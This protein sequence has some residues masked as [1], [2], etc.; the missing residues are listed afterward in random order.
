MF[1]KI[2]LVFL[3]LS[4][5]SHAQ[6][7]IKGVLNVDGD[8]PYMILYKLKGITTQY[9]AYDTIVN[10]KFS[11]AVPP[12][13]TNGIYRMVYDVPNKLFVDIIYAKENIA[14]TFDPRNPNQT[15]QFTASSNNKI[16]YEYLN[17]IEKIQKE[18]DA[19][20]ITY[21]KNA[22]EGSAQLYVQKYAELTAMQSKYEELATD[23][24]AFH[25]IKASARFNNK[26]LI[27][28]PEEY[29]K[30]TQDH[31]FD[32]IDFNSKELAESTFIFDKINDYIFF[33]NSSDDP[34]QLQVLR[35]A[36]I[37]TVLTKI[38]S[39]Y[40]LAKD[41]N[42]SLLASFA[43]QED[44]NMVNF[45]LNQYLQMPREYQDSNYIS[46]IKG[47]L[48]TAVGMKVPNITWQENEQSMDLYSLADADRYIVV[49]WSSTC[50]H[51]LKEMPLLYDYLK[52]NT[53]TKVIAVGLEDTTSKAGWKTLIGG[54]KKFTHVYGEDKWKNNYAREYGVNATPSFYVLDANKK[55]LSKPDDVEAL[56]HYFS[57]K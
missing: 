49:F 50:S 35:R 34:T 11:I 3:F 30:V 29:F 27:K 4:T 20:Q 52:D 23:K 22:S 25:F 6:Y 54:F 45:V 40:T 43:Q 36:A 21:F 18:L 1:K 26:S 41:I 7:S 14:F 57:T 5:L 53:T 56:K 38:G 32:Y 31:F 9:V 24:L 10:R 19:L 16:Y 39:N 55:V 28:T 12:K 48:R 37:Q 51:C 47:Q 13:E 33:L 8:F 46:D 17:S 15:I 2:I 42:E 44:I